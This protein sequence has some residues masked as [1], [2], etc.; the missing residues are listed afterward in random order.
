M[1]AEP[2]ALGSSLFTVL[3]GVESS[4]EGIDVRADTSLSSSESLGMVR[5][6]VGR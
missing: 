1:V 5:C 2:L 4:S 6:E 3:L